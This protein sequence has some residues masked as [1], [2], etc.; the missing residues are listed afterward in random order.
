VGGLPDALW[1]LGWI[2]LGCAAC[3]AAIR[4]SVKHQQAE[5]ALFDEAVAARYA[6]AG[7]PLGAVA[8]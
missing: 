7:L 6:A 1:D 5:K 8:S 3:S 4:F 2:V